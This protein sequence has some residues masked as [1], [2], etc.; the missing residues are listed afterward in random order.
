M[1]WSSSPEERNGSEGSSPSYGGSSSEGSLY[2]P[3]AASCEAGCSAAGSLKAGLSEEACCSVAGSGSGVPIADTVL[4]SASF[5]ASS[6][7][8]S[9]SASLASISSRRR[10]RLEARAGSG[11]AGDWQSGVGV[12]SASLC[13]WPAEGES[14]SAELS[15]RESES[16]SGSASPSAPTSAFDSPGDGRGAST[17]CAASRATGGATAC[18]AAADGVVSTHGS[19]SSL[20]ASCRNPERML[21][22]AASLDRRGN[23]I[24]GSSRAATSAILVHRTKKK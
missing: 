7:T 4:S 20:W 2:S 21:L 11:S 12:S 10:R 17:G 19:A 13:C 8:L 6:A 9:S 5:T 24:G 18:M 23:S 14:C 3:P 22:A 15:A 1:S 16:W